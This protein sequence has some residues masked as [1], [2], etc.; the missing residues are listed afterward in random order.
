MQL[1]IRHFYGAYANRIRLNFQEQI[2]PDHDHAKPAP[3]R[4]ASNKR[5]AELIYRIYQV[6]PLTC[7][8]CAA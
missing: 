3:S 6:D 4:R 2:R 7:T 5:W 8:Q 1:T